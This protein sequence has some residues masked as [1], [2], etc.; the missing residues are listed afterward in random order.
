MCQHLLSEKS[1]CLLQPPER[2]LQL[3]LQ[4]PTGEEAGDCCSGGMSLPSLCG[5][6]AALMVGALHDPAVAGTTVPGDVVAEVLGSDLESLALG[7][8]WG[9]R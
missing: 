1:G 5:T 9:R 8:G 6:L 7:E 2:Q 3:Q 4:L